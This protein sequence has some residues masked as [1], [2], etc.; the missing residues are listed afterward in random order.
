MG[1]KEIT[2]VAKALKKTKIDLIFASPFKRTTESAEIVAQALK[3]KIIFDPR[4]Q[5]VFLAKYHGRPKSEWR[6]DFPVGRLFKAKPRGGED[7]NDVRKRIRGFLTGV[8][9]KHQDKNILVVGHGDPLFL[10][11]GL[12]KGATN[13]EL[14]DEILVKK[15]YLKKAELRKII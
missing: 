11:E 6:R 7:W 10:L 3:L 15:T 14:I 13:Q 9:K 4:L 12:I 5:D 8:E 2:R 1:K